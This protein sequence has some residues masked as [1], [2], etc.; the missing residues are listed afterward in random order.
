MLVPSLTFL[1][2]FIVTKLS[3]SRTPLQDGL[4]ALVLKVSFIVHLRERSLSCDSNFGILAKQSRQFTAL[5]ESETL[6]YFQKNQDTHWIFHG[7][8]PERIALEVLIIFLLQ[9]PGFIL[10]TWLM[11]ALFLLTSALSTGETPWLDLKSRTTESLDRSPFQY[12][13]PNWFD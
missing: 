11:I 6:M 7:M 9:E 8:V 3:K 4:L 5:S 10:S 12:G 13:G 1:N 2:H